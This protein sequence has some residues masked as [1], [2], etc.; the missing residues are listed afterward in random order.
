VPKPDIVA[1]KEP[2][3]GR[4]LHI[5]QPQPREQMTGFS[6][7][8]ALPYQA[9]AALVL[10]LLTSWPARA[11]APPD[12]SGPCLIPWPKSLN[13]GE[14][15]LTLTATARIIA[16]GDS[17]AG[18]AAILGDEIYQTTGVR[19]AAATGKG[20]KGDITLS[21]DTSLKGEAQVV[22]IT[23]GGVSVRGA[24]Y[25]AVALGTATL[26]QAITPHGT[27][28]L[29]PVMRVDDEPQ[30]AYGGTMVDVARRYNSLDHLRQVVVM[31]RLYKI[32]FLHLHLSDDPAWLFP[33]KSF[34]VLGKNS[35]WNGGDSGPAPYDLNELLAFVKFADDRGVTVVPEIEASGH[36]YGLQ[37][38]M[39]EIFGMKDPKTG[40]FTSIS[41][42][43]NMANEDGIY[44]AF[45]KLIGDLAEVFKSS[46]YIHLGGDEAYWNN[47]AASEEGK[48]YMARKGY[49]TTQVYAYFLNKLNA[50]VKKHGKK[51]IVW[52]GFDPGGAPFDRDIVVMAW[53]GSHQGLI[54]A[55]F[56]II[57]VPWWPQ[58]SSS[59]R[60]NY[61]WN[62]WQVG[63]EYGAPSQLA[64][65]NAVLGAEMVLWECP[66]REIIR[67]LRNKA[68]PRNEMVY[69]PDNQR[70]FADFARRFKATDEIL[71]KLI[72]PVAIQAEGL[73]RLEGAPIEDM[74]RFVHERGGFSLYDRAVTLRLTPL[75]PLPGQAIHYTLDNSE[76]TA[77]SPVYQEPI[78]IAPKNPK[79]NEETWLKVRAYSG[80]QPVGFT[81]AARYQYNAD[82]AA[83][84][85][86]KIIL[87]EVPKEM[88][89]LPADLTPLKVIYSGQQ[90]TYKVQD[91]AGFFLPNFGWT[92]YGLIAE[93][94]LHV[95]Q[96]GQYEFSGAG[97]LYLDNHLVLDGG[98][99][100]KGVVVLGAGAHPLRLSFCGKNGPAINL[101]DP[102]GKRRELSAE[103]LQP[104]PAT[105]PTPK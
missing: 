87:Y 99:S 76:P 8:N 56:K 12:G 28:L 86:V 1:V 84:R 33:S 49:N 91:L 11:E 37:R 43:I 90:P 59:M 22:E 98:K 95:K 30:S 73:A 54:N 45:E 69:N 19:L 74:E 32:R 10:M 51:T 23:K 63:Q 102:A 100:E 35:G 48:A 88:K 94:T 34:P 62:I 97:E 31:C 18:L 57:N 105:P 75:A 44:P 47:W 89:Q 38:G 93:A 24:N 41:G 72:L 26:L 46:P 101:V 55:G 20:G 82:A 66:G 60:K 14:G 79:A 92:P 17:L 70:T 40:K 61:E 103:D 13:L 21:C 29:L 15:H 27:Q 71:E 96:A 83:P 39:E 50:M 77:A 67:K 81:K 25:T 16:D 85:S 68:V 78:R 4:R 9:L 42:M 5:A 3:A 64:R 36:S 6:S 53:G 65:T 7:R 52:E 80:S 104:E 58:A 2:A